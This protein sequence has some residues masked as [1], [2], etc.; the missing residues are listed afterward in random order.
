M[1]AVTGANGLLG[2]F[3]VR[4]L[5][6]KNESFV[7]F[8]RKD[9]DTSLLK[10]IEGKI[11]WR[12][13]DVCDYVSLEENLSG[14]TTVIHA[15]ALV[16]F[17]PREEK[18]MFQINV[19]GTKNLVNACL[20]N[21]VKR[22]IHVS[23]IAALGRHKDASVI[24]ENNKWTDDASNTAYAESKYLAELEVFRGQEEG[25]STVVVNPSV[26]LAP[27]NWHQSSAQIF[28]YIWNE[29]P[30]YFNAMLNVVDVRD[31]VE[32]ICRFMDAPNESE[33]FIINAGTISIKDLFNRIAGAFNKK[34]PSVAVHKKLLT[35][36]ALAEEVRT[37]LTRTTPLLTRETAR[38]AGTNIFCNNQKVKDV[39]NYEF[40]SIDATLHWCC[41]YYL[42]QVNG[43]K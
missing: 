25:L 27:A 17:N 14:V 36:I 39:L 41:E 21:G 6:E 8:R 2:S 12:Y 37:F 28:R 16:S 38:I 22:L 33:R 15:A 24:D 34:A 26:I 18:K 7:A 9:S 4:K 35:L 32:I 30:F 31:V 13:S 40:R 11:D 5:A 3:L 42:R 29:R 43:K 1:I 20:A 10:D 19:E 23:S